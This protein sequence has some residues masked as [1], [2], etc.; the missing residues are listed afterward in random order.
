MLQNI[1]HTQHLK[2]LDT[3]WIQ[4]NIN[5]FQLSQFNTSNTNLIFKIPQKKVFQTKIV[6]LY[7]YTST[8]PLTSF[9]ALT[10]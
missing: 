6:F 1:T 10:S 3:F 2:D 8:R 9:S 4:F 7:L 5:Y